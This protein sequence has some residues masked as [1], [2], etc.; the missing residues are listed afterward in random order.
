[1]RTEQLLHSW[2]LHWRTAIVWLNADRCPWVLKL[3]CCHSCCCRWL[4][5][6]T[7]SP[8]DNLPGWLTWNKQIELGK[9]KHLQTGRHVHSKRNSKHSKEHKIRNSVPPRFSHNLTA[10][11]KGCKKQT[12][13]MRPQRYQRKIPQSY[14]IYLF[15]HLL[16][17]S[18]LQLSSDTPEE[19]IRSHYG[20]LWATMWLPGFELRTFRRAVSALNHWAISPAPQS[21]FLKRTLEW[22]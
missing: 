10:S 19:G 12:K 18:T 11:Q 21:Y 17:V 7:L 14:F 20:W 8:N 15:I 6:W 4:C 5:L 2:T 22:P 1:M 9:G 3:S 16:Y 13:I